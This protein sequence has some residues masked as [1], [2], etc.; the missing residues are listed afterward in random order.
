MKIRPR[1]IFLA[2]FSVILAVILWLYVKT[3]K[4]YETDL[5]FKLQ[6]TDVPPK[7]MVAAR[8]PK[9]VHIR[10]KGKGKRLLT[11]KFSECVAKIS[12]KNFSYGRKT[13][14]L[15]EQ[16][17]EFVSPDIKLVDII[18]PKQITIFLDRRINK[19]VPVKLRVEV[20]PDEGMYVSGPLKVEPEE[21]TIDGPESRVRR[22]SYVSTVPET[23]EHINTFTS[24]LVPLE[25][26][27]E[28]VTPVPDTV[29]V[30][31]GVSRL[32]QKKFE[33][34]KIIPKGFPLKSGQISPP[35]VDV[36]VAGPDDVI[37]KLSE[38]DIK[39][40]VLYTDIP[41]DERNLKIVEIK[42][43]VSVPKDVRLVKT[44]PEYVKFIRAEPQEQESE[45]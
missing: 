34:V 38:K 15:S 41:P 18:T 33:G 19:K 20:I 37:G 16:N 5:Y 14:T 28:F 31:V 6:I 42:P 22:I 26:P 39:V 35:T 45:K 44:E 36:I 25:K 9:V 1:Q 29:M 40:Y 13:I 4:E 3:E 32:V 23:V 30:S 21:V 7:Y 43:S 12:L 27:D 8:V 11:Q 2:V 17:F 24:F 10:V